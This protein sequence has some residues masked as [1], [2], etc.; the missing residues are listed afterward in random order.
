MDLGSKKWIIIIIS[1]ILIC[2]I[3][4]SYY[5]FFSNNDII[6]DIEEGPPVIV[7]L[8]TASSVSTDPPSY[9]SAFTFSRGDTIWLY[10]EYKNVTHSG[11]SNL[12]IE[13]SIIHEDGDVLGVI[14]DNIDKYQKASFYYFNTNSS[15]HDGVYIVSSK[16]IDIISDETTVKSTTFYLL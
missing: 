11:V 10:Q 4:G 13:I 6:I 1:V 7:I 3:I 8:E 9:V 16:L 14:E 5:L 2:T 12:N 15:W